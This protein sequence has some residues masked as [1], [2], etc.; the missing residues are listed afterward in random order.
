[1][2]SYVF[3]SF[4]NGQVEGGGGGRYGRNHQLLT[5]SG[6]FHK[7]SKLFH[8]FPCHLMDILATCWTVFLCQENAG[9]LSWFPSEGDVM[10]E[11]DC[12]EG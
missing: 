6:S 8:Q 10:R 3:L 1:M 5:Y 9:Y 7:L 11:T 4:L 12:S 2:S